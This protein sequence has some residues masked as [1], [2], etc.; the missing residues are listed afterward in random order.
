RRADKALAGQLNL[1]EEVSEGAQNSC[2]AA[3][4][5]P[6][7]RQPADLWEGSPAPL[8]GVSANASLSK[9]VVPARKQAS[10][11]GTPAAFPVAQV[12]PA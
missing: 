3:A 4:P 5:L 12:Q 8:G 2:A 11:R 1:F 7:L 6:A 9:V 10:K